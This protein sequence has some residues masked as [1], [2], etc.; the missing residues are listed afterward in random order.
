MTEILITPISKVTNPCIR[1]KQL[2]KGLKICVIY[3]KDFKEQQKSLIN[4]TDEE[5]K[6]LYYECKELSYKM[7]DKIKIN[8]EELNDFIVK[9]FRIIEEVIEYEEKVVP[10]P[11]Y[12]L[13]LWL[14]DGHSN[15]ISLTNIDKDII[16]VWKKYAEDNGLKV[17]KNGKKERKSDIKDYETELT[18]S[19]NI[20]NE[21]GKGNKI[22]E[23]FKDLKL[24][25]N[26]HI[27]DIYLKNSVKVRLELLA[28]LIDT[29][30][31]KNDN[32][33]EITQKNEILSN[34][35]EELSKSLGFNTLKK[36]STKRCKNSS[37]KNH[38]GIYYRIYISTNK[39]SLKVP[40]ICERKKIC[41]ENIKFESNY[42]M[43]EDGEKKKKNNLIWSDELLI[44]LVSTI[45]AFKKAEP[46]KTIPWTRLHLF[47]NKLPKNKSEAFRTKHRDLIKQN[48]YNN[49]LKKYKRN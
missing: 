22:L 9:N 37:N 48:K 38:Q 13:G 17:S 14:G 26:K 46:N 43:T 49:L 42:K 40:V 15:K 23:L 31:H 3:Y 29:D 7:G 24:I 11:P 30:G 28:G 25:K 36:V 20:C 41:P 21:R 12:I 5:I 33:Y 35:I 16:H 18:C 2:Q 32:M 44:H 8:K 19:Y 47:N 4:P 1:R 27:P 39:Y 6:K 45:E 10:I 34:N